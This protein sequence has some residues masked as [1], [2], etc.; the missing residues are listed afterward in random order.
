MLN[1]K[2]FLQIAAIAALLSA[3]A[4]FHRPG[5]VAASA[6]K[7]FPTITRLVGRDVTITITA[8]P[9]GPLYSA[10]DRAGKPLASDLTL[11]QL[12]AAHPALYKQIEP[13][14]CHTAPAC[15]AGV[16]RD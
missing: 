1:R 4:P 12:R 3:V 16:D 6:S 13:A 5:G 9:R 14:V 11:D 2:H 15:W 10:T 8:G 7:A